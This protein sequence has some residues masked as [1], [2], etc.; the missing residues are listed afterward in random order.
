MTCVQLPGDKEERWQ[1]ERRSGNRD[2]G[3]TLKSNYRASILNAKFYLITHRSLPEV[4]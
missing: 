4:E 1:K 3:C 2:R